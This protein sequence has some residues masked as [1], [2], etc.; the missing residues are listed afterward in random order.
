M[1]LNEIEKY[2]VM[3]SEEDFVTAKILLDNEKYVQ[4][5]FF[6]HLAVEK[7][8]KEIFVNKNFSEA[9]FSHN[10][11]KIASSIHAL[12]LNN[13]TKILLADITSFNINSRYDD[14]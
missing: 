8:L 5:M 10:L 1:E 7:M 4:S 2:W 3:T 12:E 13:D 14:Y 6:I 11:I 9:P